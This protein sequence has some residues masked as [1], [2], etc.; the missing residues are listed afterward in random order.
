M[1]KLQITLKF[2]TVATAA[3]LATSAYSQNLVQDGGFEQSP[4]ATSPPSMPVSG[5]FSAFW[6]V[7]DPSGPA[8]GSPLGSNT[9]VGHT[10]SL[11]FEGT[12]HANLGAVGQ[13]GTLSQILA[14]TPGRVYTFSFALANDS[15]FGPNFFQANFGT[16]TL[17]TL[18]NAPASAY[19]IFTYSVLA[20]SAST[21]LQFIYRNDDDFFRL[22]RISV[23]T[24][25][26]GATLWLMVPAFASLA[27]VHLRLNR[28]RNAS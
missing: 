14:T 12:N 15:G 10:P 13:N 1:K 6:T 11:A 20:T 23:V 16:T 7:N 19:G 17:L 4:P 26:G 18:T 5:P 9:N 3:F 22:D 2:L 27:L 25:E 24:P 8:P 21:N 28:R